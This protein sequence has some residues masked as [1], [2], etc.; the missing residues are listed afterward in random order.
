MSSFYS[1][2]SYEI[3]T[4]CQFHCGDKYLPVVKRGNR[5]AWVFA[6]DGNLRQI[7]HHIPRGHRPNALV[8]SKPISYKN[9]WQVCLV[10]ETI[11]LVHPAWVH[12]VNSNEKR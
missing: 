12:P 6:L 3:G 8:L 7:T 4:I 11:V 9:D 5:R 1:D 10:D 2:A